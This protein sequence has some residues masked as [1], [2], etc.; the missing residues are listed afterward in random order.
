VSKFMAGTLVQATRYSLNR[1]DPEPHPKYPHLYAV[2]CEEIEGLGSP[3]LDPNTGALYFKSGVAQSDTGYAKLAVLYKPLPFTL[4]SKVNT[5]AVI[6]TV[7]APAAGADLGKLDWQN[8]M[9]T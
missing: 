9:I 4:T 3:A 2:H 1:S 7:P 5:D 8:G 6:N